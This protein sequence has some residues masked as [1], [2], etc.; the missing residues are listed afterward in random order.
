MWLHRILHPH[1]PDCRAEREEAQALAEHN[2]ECQSCDILKMQL[3]E[4]NREKRELMDRLL[5]KN[6]PINIQPDEQPKLVRKTIPWNVRKQML[7]QQSR[8]LAQ[9]LRNAAEASPSPEVEKLEKE[10]GVQDG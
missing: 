7:E 10:L 5:G 1:C 8:E 4:A 2:R 3:A 9:A 6:E